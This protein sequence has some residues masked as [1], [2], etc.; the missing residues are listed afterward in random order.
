M[1]R[2]P[3]TAELASFLIHIHEVE[4]HRVCP[5]VPLQDIQHLF[6]SPRREVVVAVDKKDIFPSCGLK[7]CVSRVAEASVGGLD[8]GDQS[9]IALGVLL[10]DRGGAVRGTV[11]DT[12][13]FQLRLARLSC[14]GAFV[15]LRE[16]RIQALFK[17]GLGVVYGDHDAEFHVCAPSPAAADASTIIVR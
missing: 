12:D 5:R 14:A 4:H 1:F 11:V 2:A 6:H 17:P 8:D 10:K 7:A 15:P 3:D 13:K 16:Q 9:G